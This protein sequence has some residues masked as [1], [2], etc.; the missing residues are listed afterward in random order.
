MDETFTIRPACPGADIRDP[1]TGDRLSE[2]G[3][4]KPRTPYWLALELRGDVV[5]VQ[6]EPARPARTAKAA[7]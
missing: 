3:E 5:A 1:N 2:A 7:E 6:P 4:A